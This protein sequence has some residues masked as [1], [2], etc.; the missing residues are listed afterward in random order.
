MREES[1]SWNLNERRGEYDAMEVSGSGTRESFA[2]SKLFSCGK[3]L[4]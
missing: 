2:R 4:S 3:E 1:R